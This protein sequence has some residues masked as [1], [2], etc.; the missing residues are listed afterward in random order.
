MAEHSGP[1][2]RGSRLQIQIAVNARADELTGAVRRVFP[3]LR[4]R[5]AEI[6]WRLPRAPGYEELRNDGFLRALDLDRLAPDLRRFWPLR[7]PAWDAVGLVRFPSG[8]P[9]VVLADAANHP[10]EF[11][12][13]GLRATSQESREAVRAAIARTQR[14]LRVEA[15]PERWIEPQRG[16]RPRTSL[17]GTANRLAHL[18][19]LREV[20]GVE[21][22]L[23]RVLFVDDTARVATSR[24]RWERALDQ[25]EE[26]LCLC[27]AR[28][29]WAGHL[30]LEASPPDDAFLPP[31]Q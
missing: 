29:P 26:E 1:A 15:T 11:Y 13:A 24:F 16:G 28:V 19:F 18:Y 14:W 10:E 27:R 17:F 21:A 25:M 6:D 3:E 31:S 8:P 9:G 23:A 4:E 30:Y 2:L 12:A 20:A 22:W 7:G 5:G